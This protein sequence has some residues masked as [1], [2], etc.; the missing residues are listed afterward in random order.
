MSSSRNLLLNTKTHIDPYRVKVKEKSVFSFPGPG[1]CYQ[2][3]DKVRKVTS[4]QVSKEE[5]IYMSKILHRK[6]LGFDDS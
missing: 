5:R 6:P 2:M 4:E 1:R 3:L